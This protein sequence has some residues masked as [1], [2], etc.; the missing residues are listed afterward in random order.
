MAIVLAL[1]MMAAILP[2]KVAEAETSTDVT[3]V[4]V[5]PYISI[6]SPYHLYFKRPI[7]FQA[8]HLKGY[9]SDVIYSDDYGIGLKKD[10]TPDIIEDGKGYPSVLRIVAAYIRSKIAE[11]NWDTWFPGVEPRDK[12]YI[13][14]AREKATLLMKDYIKLEDT[15]SGKKVVAISDDGTNWNTGLAKTGKSP[16]DAKWALLIDNKTTDVALDK[17][18]VKTNTNIELSLNPVGSDTGLLDCDMMENPSNYLVVTGQEAKAMLFKS[19]VGADSKTTTLPLAD[20]AVTIYVNNGETQSEVETLKTDANGSISFKKDEP[21]LYTF[22]TREEYDDG[23][24]NVYSKTNLL[25]GS[26]YVFAK[27]TKAQS[28]KAKVT[29]KKKAKKTIKVSFKMSDTRYT[30]EYTTFNI[31]LSK[32]K[33]SGYKK[34]T[35]ANGTKLK[36]VIKGKKKGTY[37][38]KIQTLYN[39]PY[40]TDENGKYLFKILKGDFTSP[41]KVVVK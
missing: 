26:I 37:Y 23:K 7:P 16:Y 9:T 3:I 20:Q 34:V 4:E 1:V 18:P 41:K 11:Q 21:G 13:L 24:G 10:G 17:C 29:G 22:A 12:E 2:A 36:A 14:Q 40:D 35:S 38:I 28:I 30:D 39:M 25:S 19:V 5:E 15:P 32:K 8:A 33:N 27:P 6:E 31:Y